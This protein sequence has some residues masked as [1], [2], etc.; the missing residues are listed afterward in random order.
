MATWDDVRRIVAQLPETEEVSSR[1]EPAW[2]VRGKG[3]VW[4]RP[5]RKSD[6]TALGLA[7]PDGP[8]LGAHVADEGVKF[9]LCADSPEVYFTTPHFNGYPA[10]LVRL[11]VIEQDE[12]AELITDAWLA[13]APK[14]LAAAFLA[15][16]SGA[17][18]RSGAAASGG[19]ETG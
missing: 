11:D 2:R 12:L 13:K 1:G 17:S 5:L 3:I 9:A 6:L 19:G 16:R 10:V 15:D 18:D 4:E 8:I 14:R 7:A